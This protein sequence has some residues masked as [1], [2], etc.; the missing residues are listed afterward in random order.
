MNTVKNPITSLD[1]K[2]FYYSFLAGAQNLFKHQG[3]LNKINVF[4]VAD[5]DTGTN[6]ASTLQAI[7]DQTK[8]SSNIKQTTTAI[9]EAALTGARGNSGIIFAQFLHGI[10]TELHNDD[11]LDVNGFASILQK[12]SAYTYDAISNPVEGTMISVIKEWAE[13]VYTLKDKTNDFSKL[14][15]DSIYKAK[16]ALAETPQKLEI[17]AK[18][19]V[20]DA[21]AQGFVVFLEGMI[22]FLKHGKIKKLAHSR[23]PVIIQDID[24]EAVHN[25]EITYRYCT[26]AF[27]DG[28]DL[29]RKA[30]RSLLG[31][32]GDSLVIAGSSKKMRIH[33]HTDHPA[34]V[35]HQLMSYGNIRHQKVDDMVLQKDI[36][37]NRK[38]DIGLLTDSSCDLPEDIMHDYQIQMLPVYLFIGKN[39]FL[40][41]ITITP[42]KFYSIF[43]E[44]P[45]YPTTAQPGFTEFRNR[46][47]Y[48]GTHYK[49]TIAIH[50]SDKLSG[51]WSNSKKAAD[52]IMANSD[53]EI[54]VID[55]KTLSGT[56]GLLVLRAAKAI[57]EGKSHSEI[58]EQVN[59]WTT[60]TEILVSPK[61]LKYFIRGGRVS[62]AK[63]LFAL[64]SHII[65]IVSVDKNGESTVFGKA[66]SQ[67]ANINKVLKHIREKIKHQKIWGY[68]VVHAQN[69]KK[70]QWYA[71]KLKALIGKD[72]EY[73]Y[74]ISPVIGLNAGLGTV[75]VS[76]MYE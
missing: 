1:G 21:G 19:H 10:N 3:A 32:Y 11:K 75:A 57:R 16:E 5:A 28:D 39:Q 63:A 40:D 9:A 76:L 44:S 51:T 52:K 68:S 8:P 31:N 27:L 4:P 60:K 46:F 30:I 37:E 73:I 7:V 23:T 43:D 65:P 38:S 69:E 35:F 53:K 14:F 41:K 66:F 67:D 50:L 62:K 58:V 25:E 56:L 61:T 15:N 17:L 13:F 64:A 45:D 2:Q 74:S 24:L 55:S 72:P 71:E 49:S 36:L 20:V 34:D 59:D 29:D 6:L 33:I 18:S 70:A 26:E 22:E 42:E 54:S 47:A 12:A 48:L